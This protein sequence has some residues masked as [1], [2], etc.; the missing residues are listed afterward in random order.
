MQYLQ[1]LLGEGHTIAG[2]TYDVKNWSTDEYTEHD[3]IDTANERLRYYLEG[4][5]N[6]YFQEG[7][8][9]YN[10]SYAGHTM[11]DFL[12]LDEEQIRE[13][14]APVGSTAI[15]EDQITSMIGYFQDLQEGMRRLGGGDF[16]IDSLQRELDLAERG[17]TGPGGLIQQKGSMADML[18]QKIGTRRQSYVPQ[19]KTSRYGKVTGAGGG[20]DPTQ[21]YLSGVE[22]DISA[23]GTSIAGVDKSIY[24]IL[25]GTE[26]GSIHDIYGQYGEGVKGSLIGPGGDL[27]YE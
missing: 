3:L 15:S 6:P 14:L 2:E 1:T 22:G 7:G 16:G 21:S 11:E 5:S 13:M 24:D 25:Y 12:G 8:G 19:E 10:E 27:W 20:V 18:Q 4:S 17:V 26:A 9:G 23:Y